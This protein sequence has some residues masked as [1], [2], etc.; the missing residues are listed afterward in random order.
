MA[1]I[2]LKRSGEL[3]RG[4][5]NLLMEH[6]DGALAREILQEL[7]TRVPPTPF[8]S[9]SYSS[10]PETRRYE[11]IVRFQSIPAVKAGWLTKNK[12]RWSLTEDGRKAFKQF[13]D[14]EQFMRESVRLYKKWEQTQPDEVVGTAQADVGTGP[15]SLEEAEERAW[16][17][18]ETHLAEMSPYDF[19]DLVAGLLRGMGYHVAWIS[20]PGADGGVDVI[21]HSDPLG[22]SGPRIKVQ[23]KR[24]PDSRTG[25]DGIRSFMAILADGDVGLFVASGGFSKDAEQEA[26]RQEKRRIMLVDLDRLFDLWVEHYTKIPEEQRR[27][28]PLKKVYF[29]ADEE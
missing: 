12:G 17:Q 26:R 27:L 24:K 8:E 5:F 3:V 23:V 20:P 16:A 28:L 19:Q 10:S 14:P 6:S 7:E 11:R 4:V 29:L 1:E 15:V 9:T 21:A 13:T 22:I 2:T 18:I 25:V